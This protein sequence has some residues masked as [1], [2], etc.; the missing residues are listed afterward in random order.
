MQQQTKSASYYYT[1][2]NCKCGVVSSYTVLSRANTHGCSQLKCQ[3]LRVGVCTEEVLKWFDYPPARAHPDVKVIYQV[4]LNWLASSLRPCFVE[5]RPTV[6]KAVTCYEVDWLVTS[7]PSF[8]CVQ[9]SLSVCEFCAAEEERCE[10]SHGQVCANLMSRHPRRVRT[11]AAMW[12]TCTGI[13]SN[14]YTRI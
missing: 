5:A 12:S 2:S 13:P 11:I 10:R 1:L 3:N 4:A 9:S 7:L 8:R 6:E 14:H